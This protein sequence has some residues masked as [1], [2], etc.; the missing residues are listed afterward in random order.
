MKRILSTFGIGSALA[1]ATITGV[2]A[3]GATATPPPAPAYQGAQLS[4]V[5]NADTVTGS[6][7]AQSG[8]NATCAQTSFF[9]RG[10]RIVFR[11]WGTD[12]PGGGYSLTPTNVLSAV[13]NL[14]PLPGTKTPLVLPL[15]YVGEPYTAPAA[16]QV[17]YWETSW[18]VPNNYPL[19]YVNYSVEF[20]TLKTHVYPAFTGTWSEEQFPGKNSWLQITT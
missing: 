9:K 16:Q 17:G 7:T 18:V 15:S 12:V 13:V 5:V 4:V 8:P 14:P 10:G 1:I 20:K 19:G 11:A 3:A 6:G 2:V